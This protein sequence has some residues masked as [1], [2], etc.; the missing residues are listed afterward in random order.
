VLERGTGVLLAEVTCLYA[1]HAGQMS[2][3]RGE[4]LATSAYVMDKYAGRPW[5]TAALRERLAVVDR[6]DD[7]Q[8]ARAERNW[9][10][11]RR[12]GRWL[13]AKPSRAASLTKLWAFRRH[14]RHRPTN[15]P[16]LF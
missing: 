9:A 2:K 1:V 15:A 7:L 5:M 12:Q 14:V 8:A 3:H 10:E 6:W 16:E 13:L 4:M 11:V